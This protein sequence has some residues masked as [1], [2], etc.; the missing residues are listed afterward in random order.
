[1]KRADEC[2]RQLQSEI[3]TCEKETSRFEAD[4]KE[5]RHQLDETGTS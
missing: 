3:R 1:M 5:T 4:L 2:E